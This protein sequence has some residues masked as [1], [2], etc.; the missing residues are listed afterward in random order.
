MSE[1]KY[2]CHN[3]APFKDVNPV[4]GSG[5]IVNIPNRMTR[6]CQYRHTDLGKVDVKCEG[7]SWRNRDAS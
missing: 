3:R 2:G 1:S 4:M 6:E 7:C 5:A